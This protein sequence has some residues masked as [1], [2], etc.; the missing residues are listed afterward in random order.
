M[1]LSLPELDN[2][3]RDKLIDSSGRTLKDFRRSLQPSFGRVWFDI[4]AGYVALGVIVAAVIAIDQHFPRAFV[5]TALLGGLAIG[6]V[7]AFLQLFFHEAAHF[8][9]ARTRAG[10]DLLANLALGL[11]TGQNIKAY[12]V[13]HM[14]HHRLLGTPTDTE[15]SYFDALNARFLLESLTGVR[16]LRVMLA[17]RSHVAE[18]AQQQAS[19]TARAARGMLIAGLVFNLALLAACAWARC[20]SL[21]F[22]WPFGMII[23][24]PA[25]TSI[26]QLL[27]HRSYDAKSSVDYSTSPHGAM[28]RMFGSGPLASTL[29]GAGFNRHL[30]HH[31]DPQLSYTNFVAMEE[32]LLDTPAEP[33]IRGATTTYVR[34]LLR[35]MKSP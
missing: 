17:R 6:Y 9:I 34:A 1:A 24:L 16:L 14:D 4:G 2:L 7:L 23:V 19:Q 28:T 33:V 31:W 18:K 29:G 5:L 15:H 11:I 20:W 27:E 3:E 35:L 25:V 21:F 26:R 30:L 13:V 8:N 22:A 32:F 12:R 10:N